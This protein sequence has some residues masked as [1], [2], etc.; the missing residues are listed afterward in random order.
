MNCLNQD[1]QD[2]ADLQDDVVESG[3]SEC[4]SRILSDGADD[5]NFK[6]DGIIIDRWVV[7]FQ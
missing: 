7:S 3:L 4:R 2:L 6:R 1:S 5:A